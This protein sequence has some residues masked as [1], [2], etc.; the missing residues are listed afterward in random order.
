MDMLSVE[1]GEHQIVFTDNTGNRVEINVTISAGENYAFYSP[2]EGKLRWNDR[3]Y[4]SF[5]DGAII[6]K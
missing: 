3:E 4:K 1:P 5:A 6:V 2:A